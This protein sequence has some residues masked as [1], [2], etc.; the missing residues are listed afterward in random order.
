MRFEHFLPL[1]ENTLYFSARRCLRKFGLY[2]HEPEIISVDVDGTIIDSFSGYDILIKVF[3][4]EKA[5]ALE[6]EFRRRLF[7]GSSIER[8]TINGIEFL[9]SMGVREKDL[10]DLLAD[11]ERENKVRKNLVDALQELKRNGKI[12]LVVTKGV[13]EFAKLIAEKYGFDDGIGTK[14][15]DGK[16]VEL[17]GT[18]EGFVDG[19]PI[20][21]KITKV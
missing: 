16:V 1:I 11:Y 15:V 4:F 10:E 12:V 19:V 21:T 2:G 14:V 13:E 17:I 7:S 6:E 18:R 8:E 3:G 5:W 20:K 9:Y